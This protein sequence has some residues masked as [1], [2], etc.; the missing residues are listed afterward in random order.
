MGFPFKIEASSFGN[1][2]EKPCENYIIRR[3]SVWN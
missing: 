3:A 1:E 2:K